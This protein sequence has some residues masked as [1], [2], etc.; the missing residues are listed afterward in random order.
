MSCVQVLALLDR[1]K[2]Q[3]AGDIE[4]PPLAL[5]TPETAG[6]RDAGG[7][8]EGTEDGFLDLEGGDNEGEGF[9]AGDYYAEDYD[10]DDDENEDRTADV[11]N[12][13]LSGT[14]PPSPFPHFLGFEG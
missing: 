6:K 12:A 1:I 8:E 7:R 9:L 2:R 14:P 4:P 13:Y 5:R 11:I 10:F 3:D